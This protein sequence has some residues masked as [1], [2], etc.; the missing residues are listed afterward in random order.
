ME[1]KKFVSTTFSW[2]STAAVAKNAP[3]QATEPTE[4]EIV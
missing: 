1:S 2:L 3:F 4:M